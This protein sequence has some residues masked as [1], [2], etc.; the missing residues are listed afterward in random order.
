[1]LNNHKAPPRPNTHAEHAL[2]NAILDNSFP[3]G[4]SLPGERT[5]A[6]QLGVT[7]PP[8]REALQRLAR[9]GWLT[10]RQGKP[11]IV[12]DYLQDGGLNVLSS[13]VEHSEHLPP[14]FVTHLLEVRLNLAP[15]YTCAAVKHVPQVVGAVLGKHAQLEDSPQAMA[16]FDWKLHRCLT[17]ASQNPIYPLILNGFADFYEQLAEVYFSSQEGR[18]KSM[19]FYAELATAVAN[20]DAQAAEEISRAA[21][22]ESLHLWQQ[23]EAALLQNEG[24][25]NA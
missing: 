14:N 9:D 17:V 2:I 11:T 3:P 6:A 4:S 15:A 1:M 8:L 25:N 16:G 13:L 24:V 19:L 5:L 23:T 10:V 7:R 20:H 22:R 21:M 18:E 12:N